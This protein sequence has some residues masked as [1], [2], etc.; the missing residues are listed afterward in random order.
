[1]NKLNLTLHQEYD[2]A[3]EVIAL[4]LPDLAIN[5]HWRFLRLTFHFVDFLLLYFISN[6][7][8]DKVV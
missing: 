1:M 8:M 2:F 5:L 3:I 4:A 7:Y 6:T